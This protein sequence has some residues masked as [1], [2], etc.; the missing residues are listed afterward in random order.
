[1][2]VGRPPHTMPAVFPQSTVSTSPMFVHTLFDGVV[3][4]TFDTFQM[5]AAV[6][7][8]TST[9]LNCAPL[10]PR[11]NSPMPARAPPLISM[12]DIAKQSIVPCSLTT[13]AFGPDA[14]PGAH[15]I[16]EYSTPAD[17]CGGCI[18]RA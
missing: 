9:L 3:T 15:R 13:A 8:S 1:M 16:C 12:F 11:L 4:P 10:T 17:T 6:Q 18:L 14:A 2:S 7:S 5:C